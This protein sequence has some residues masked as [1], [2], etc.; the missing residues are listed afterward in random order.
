[1]LGS[2]SIYFHQDSNTLLAKWAFVYNLLSAKGYSVAEIMIY[3]KAYEYFCQNPSQYDGATIVKDLVDIPGLDLDA[4]LHDYHYI[5]FNAGA[6]FATKF[7]VDWL[8]A[9]GTERKGKGLYS[10]Y[11][12]F[13]GLTITSVGF[14]PY[15][16][17][18]RGKTINK[19]EINNH[20]KTLLTP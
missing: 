14:V 3:K 13:I 7:K 10:A 19:T 8:F 11:S 5:V 20:Y 9:K 1:M 4:M 16:F 15:A 12:R 17:I 6:N 18:K 2:T